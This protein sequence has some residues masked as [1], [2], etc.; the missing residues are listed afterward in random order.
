MV[1]LVRN[2]SPLPRGL[3]RRAVHFAPDMGVRSGVVLAAEG[4]AMFRDRFELG[5]DASVSAIVDAVFL[6]RVDVSSEP[7]M[8]RSAGIALGN[9]ITA[10]A[11]EWR[12]VD[13]DRPEVLVGGQGV[14]VIGVVAAV[15][16]G[17][18]QPVQHIQRLLARP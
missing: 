16:A 18:T 8:R 9:A 4:D 17:A 11:G 2:R 13:E 12:V 3:E 6:A 10:E 5:D 15:C 7:T 1:A 14:D